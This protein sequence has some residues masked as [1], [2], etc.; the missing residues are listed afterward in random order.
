MAM[1]ILTARKAARRPVRSVAELVEASSPPDKGR[2]ILRRAVPVVFLRAT[3]AVLGLLFWVALS[4]IL[5]PSGVGVLRQG[6]AFLMVS[7]VVIRFGLDNVLL[8]EVAILV[9]RGDLG[10]A[11]GLVRRAMAFSLKVGCFVAVVVGCLALVFFGAERLASGD[12]VVWGICGL[13]ALPM[14]ILTFASEAQKGAGRAVWGTFLQFNARNL[15]FLPALVVLIGGGGLALAGDTQ[16][17]TRNTAGLLVGALVIAAGMGLAS[18]YRRAGSSE[19][20][21]LRPHLRSAIPLFQCALFGVALEWL[22]TLV[23]GGFVSDADVGVYGAAVSAALVMSF[24]LYAANVIMAPRFA[25]AFEDGERAL[26]EREAK[27]ATRLMLFVAIPAVTILFFWGDVLIG[28]FGVGFE[29]AKSVFRILLLG[30]AFNMAT[31]PVGYLLLMGRFE[32]T[33]RN[34]IA[35]AACADL[36]LLAILVPMYGIVGAAWATTTAMALVNLLH[37]MAC[38]RELGFSTIGG[39]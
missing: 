8:R 23:L 32:H 4:R 25:K 38:R 3:G 31:G 13:G 5:G 16:I 18:W 26:L 21:P 11:Q 33:F 36:I 28:T 20:P 6:I 24:L 19:S 1:A 7:A 37:F 29:G 30:H 22:D 34:N 10:G 12:L 27:S 17:A 39:R 35:I 15:I 2:A 14:A 9:G